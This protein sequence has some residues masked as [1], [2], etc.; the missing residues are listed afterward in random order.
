MTREMIE[1]YGIRPGGARPPGAPPATVYAPATPTRRGP[2][3][4]LEEKQLKVTLTV[5]AVRL[6]PTAE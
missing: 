3:T 2:E 6:P 5:E 4:V 1:R